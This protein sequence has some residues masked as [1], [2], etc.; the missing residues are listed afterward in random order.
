MTFTLLNQFLVNLCTIFCRFLCFIISNFRL[1]P[2]EVIELGLTVFVDQGERYRKSYSVYT[3]HAT[4]RPLQRLFVMTDR[5]IYLL[6]YKTSELNDA[7]EALPSPSSQ[8]DETRPRAEFH[9]HAY[10]HFSDIDCICVGID[11]QIFAIECT[12]K[13]FAMSFSD[14][15]SRNLYIECGSIELTK[16]LLS[17]L[18]QSMIESIGE[19]PSI[20]TDGTPS[21]IT[22][23]KFVNNELEITNAS[24]LHHSLIYWLEYAGTTSEL[25]ALEG[26][27][28]FRE[29]KHK[30]WI[31]PYGDWKYAYFVLKYVLIFFCFK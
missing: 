10:V 22:L 30:N 11:Y 20:F 2:Y 26:Y 18:K 12:H 16:H 31:K 17:S 9:L 8:I 27:L 1:E 14:H 24:I 29:V 15:E 19:T 4:G 25:D 5:R 21:S 28:S 23:K 7:M 6:S 13:K 3:D